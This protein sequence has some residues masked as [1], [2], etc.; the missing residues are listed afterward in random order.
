MDELEENIENLKK[1]LAEQEEQE[2][3]EEGDDDGVQE[4]EE[5]ETEEVEDEEKPEEDPQEEEKPDASAFARMRREKRAAERAKAA[6]DEEKE[7]LL[8]QI[9]EL[10]SG[11]YEKQVEPQDNQMNDIIR[12]HTMQQAQ[13]EFANYEAEFRKV[14]PNYDAVSKQYMQALLQSIKVQN[15]RASDAQVFEMYKET[16]LSK[17][18]AYVREGLDPVEELYNEALDL[19]FSAQKEV[20]KDAKPDM[21]KVARNRGR[22]ASMAGTSAEGKGKLTPFAAADMSADEWSKLP[23]SEKQEVFA[24]LGIVDMHA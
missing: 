11:K 24:Q 19:G 12:S 2:K 1:Q 22:S 13:Q 8:R 4:G 14:E 23:D 7:A 17:A 16:V 21:S 18:G 15:P 9:E 5:S 10:K 6:A 3:P 20:K